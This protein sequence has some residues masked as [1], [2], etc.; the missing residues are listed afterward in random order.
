MSSG[1]GLYSYMSVPVP[2]EMAVLVQWCGVVHVDDGQKGVGDDPAARGRGRDQ[3]QAQVLQNNKKLNY[4]SCL[5]ID[6]FIRKAKAK[7]IP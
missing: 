3:S 6:F 7:S 4:S 2:V 1:V 5:L